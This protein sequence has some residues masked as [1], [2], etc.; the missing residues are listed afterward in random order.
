M[1]VTLRLS[2]TSE[3]RSAFSMMMETWNTLFRSRSLNIHRHTSHTVLTH[4]TRHV[5]TY[6]Q[7]STSVNIQGNTSVNIRGNTHVAHAACTTHHTSHDHV[8]LL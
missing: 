2:V 6:I 4:T 1:V 5:N 3:T 7:A 8:V